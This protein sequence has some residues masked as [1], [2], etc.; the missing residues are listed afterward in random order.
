MRNIVFALVI[1][2]TLSFSAT[3]DEA[4]IEYQKGNF[5]KAFS[6][7]EKLSIQGNSMAQ[8]RFGTM[9]Y[10]G[11]GVKKDYEKSSYWF[12][13]SANQGNMA[14][15]F[16]MGY[17]YE[18]GIGVKQDIDKAID[19]YSTSAIKGNPLALN[20]I[21]QL[22]QELS[23]KATEHF[24][25][26]DY[27]IALHLFEKAALLQHRD[28]QYNAGMM[29]Y[30]GYGV[31]KDNVLASF[32]L[33]KAANQGDNEAKELLKDINQLNIKEAKKNA[34]KKL[35]NDKN[36]YFLDK[37]ED[38]ERLLFNSN[39]EIISKSQ[40]L[41]GN[42]YRIAPEDLVNRFIKDVYYDGEISEKEKAEKEKAA[43]ELLNDTK[44]RIKSLIGAKIISG[45]VAIAHPTLNTFKLL[46]DGRVCFTSFLDS[47]ECYH[48]YRKDDAQLFAAVDS[49]LIKKFRTVERYFN[50]MYI[51]QL[52][53]RPKSNMEAKTI[54]K[55]QIAIRI[56]S[57]TITKV[58]KRR[59]FDFAFKDVDVEI[60][61]KVT[62]EKVEN[63]TAV[64]KYMDENGQLI[65]KNIVQ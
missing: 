38:I 35:E 23:N 40:R 56:N 62:G 12:E 4:E 36:N 25:N 43:V 53:I 5:D 32:W 10:M 1:T 31:T 37:Q 46:K 14:G 42:I 59:Q 19:L 64:F 48:D 44:S 41:D 65:S 33:E 9:Y 57:A 15:E 34:R 6:L 11:Q 52:E 7:F 45:E 3:F 47:P 2:L 54:V 28:S 60:V 22:P 27:S 51:T 63:L 29:Y 50:N 8:Q 26:R 16:S 39:F 49:N 30:K 24:E 18:K 13:K 21:S 20:R 58:F 61:D 55:N 17:N